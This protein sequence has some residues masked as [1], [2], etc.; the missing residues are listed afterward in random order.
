MAMPSLGSQLV[1]NVSSR[2]ALDFFT[3]LAVP[4]VAPRLGC[5]ATD[6]YMAGGGGAFKLAACGGA[7]VIG[8]ETGGGTGA[9]GGAG[10][11][12]LLAAGGSAWG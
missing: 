10:G 7:C 3:R 5:L 1:P 12:G 11:A 6:E 4:A 2:E 8:L 9:L